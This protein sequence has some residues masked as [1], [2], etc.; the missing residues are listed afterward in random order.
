MFHSLADAHELAENAW[1]LICPLLSN[2]KLH[3]RG[4]HAVPKRCYHSKI[5]NT[6][7][8]IKLVL[9]QRLMTRNF[10][11]KTHS[12]SFPNVFGHVLVMDRNEVKTPIFAINMRNKLGDLS[13]KFW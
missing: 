3:T 5:S 13:F 10:I 4:V 11:S 12:E 7:K 1:A 9:F 8:S 6:E 2:D